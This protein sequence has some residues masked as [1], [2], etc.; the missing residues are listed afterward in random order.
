[1]VG[2]AVLTISGAWAF[3]AL[4]YLPCELCLKQRLAYY[5]GIP[6]AVLLVFMV[7]GTRYKSLVG[8]AFV[9]L[10][11]IFG[12]NALFG[13]YHAGVEWGFWPG[14]SECSGA[15]ASAAKVGDFLK[16][17]ESVKVVRCDAVAIRILGL[18]L[19]GWNAVICAAL[20]GL[21]VTGARQTLSLQKA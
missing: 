15:A 9:A 20:S 18:S 10:A 8:P 4:G 16:Q 14:P 7:Q 2:L 12:A 1:M 21:G 17:L 19:A 6:L 5:Y 13:V 3:Q 11:L